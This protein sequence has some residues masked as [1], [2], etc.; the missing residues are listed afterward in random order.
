MKSIGEKQE[1]M[2][3]GNLRQGDIVR[4]NFDPTHGHEQKSFR[5]ALIVSNHLVQQNSNV[6]LCCPISHT[7]R[8]FPLYVDL[9]DYLSTDGKI[10]L[11]Q[12][13]SLDLSDRGCSYV[14]S[15]KENDLQDILMY[16][17]L[18]FENER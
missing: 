7:Q 18:M 11:D 13:R 17:K 9:P 6:W 4:V 8:N 16:L 1:E 3:I 2:N 12:V 15:L 10:L 5:P 14:E